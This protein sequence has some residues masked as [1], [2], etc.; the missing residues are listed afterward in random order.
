MFLIKSAFVGKKALYQQLLLLHHWR[1]ARLSLYLCVCVCVCV[2]S[3]EGR[4][5]APVQ[6]MLLRIFDL[7]TMSNGGVKN[8]AV[9]SCRVFIHDK[10][11]W[12]RCT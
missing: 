4:G 3:G 5:G 11:L 8:Y 7:G 10:T 9:R 6:K 2:W 12:H 1:L